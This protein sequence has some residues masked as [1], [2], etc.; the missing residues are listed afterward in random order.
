MDGVAIDLPKNGDHNP[1][2]CSGNRRL[3]ALVRLGSS[4]FLET[5][6]LDSLGKALSRL[7]D[8]VGP[9]EQQFNSWE[10]FI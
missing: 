8:V 5:V 3:L 4:F 2:C 9:F 10:G 6:R 7:L 1:P